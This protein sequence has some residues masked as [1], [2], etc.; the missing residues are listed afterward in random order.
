MPLTKDQY[1]LLVDCMSIYENQRDKLSEWELGFIGGKG[2]N[3]QYDSLYEKCE[4]YGEDVKITEKQ[5]QV[6]QRIYDKVALGK[7]PEFRGR[8]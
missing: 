4:K 1:D 2:P 3:D 8:S 7:K 5:L 6:L